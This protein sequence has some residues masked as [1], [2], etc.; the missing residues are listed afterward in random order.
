M[1]AI[2]VE[3]LNMR[4]ATNAEK[5]SRPPSRI[6]RGIADGVTRFFGQRDELAS[7]SWSAISPQ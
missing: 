5:A 3:A 4:N 7:Q 6:A 2:F 1:P